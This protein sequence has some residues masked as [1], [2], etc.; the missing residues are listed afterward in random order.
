MDSE[1]VMAVV[2][3]SSAAGSALGVTSTPTFFFD[4]QL[5]GE[6]ATS[7]GDFDQQLRTALDQ[8]IG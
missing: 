7:Y 5:F 2:R 6:T 4:G 8:G 1:S 3:E